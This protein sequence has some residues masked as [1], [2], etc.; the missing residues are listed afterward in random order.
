MIGGLYVT[1]FTSI[2][3][4]R[5]CPRFVLSILFPPFEL[6]I[7]SFTYV[8]DRRS[9]YP[10]GCLRFRIMCPCELILMS[11]S[12]TLLFLRLGIILWNWWHRDFFSFFSSSSSSS[13]SSCL[14]VCLFLFNCLAYSSVVVVDFVDIFQLGVAYSFC[15]IPIAMQ[16][17]R[18]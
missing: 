13:S 18:N 11:R 15:S 12:T 6:F 16:F 9:Q 5:L 8:Y 3:H 17:W 1:F 4:T 10:F 7:T 14:C 2:T